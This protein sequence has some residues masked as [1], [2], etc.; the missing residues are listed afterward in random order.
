MSWSL[1]L[2]R[3]PDRQLNRIPDRQV[4]EESA[5]DLERRVLAAKGAQPERIIELFHVA[6]N[7]LKGFR[8]PC[9]AGPRHDGRKITVAAAVRSGKSLP[10]GKILIASL[11]ETNVGHDCQRKRVSHLLPR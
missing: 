1:T 11:V 3:N 8:R 6:V 7:S 4:L 9:D 2:V 5:F 10:I